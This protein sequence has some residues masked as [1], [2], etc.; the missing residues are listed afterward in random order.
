MITVKNLSFSYNSEPVLNDLNFEAREGE[1]TFILGPNG[2]GK[3][4]LLKCIAGILKPRGAILVENQ[5]LNDISKRELAKKLAY[6]PQRGDTGFL[7]VFDVI[8]LGRKPYMGFGPTNRDYRIV[9]DVMSLL[10]L[11]KLAFR[12]LN[13][14]SG[15]ELQ[16][17]MIARALAQRPRILL[18]DE[19]TNNLDVKNQIEIMRLIR[20]IAKESNISVI[21]TMHD[22][23]LASLYADRIL[24][25]KNGKIFASGGIE[26]L[27]KENIKAVYGVDVEV[28]RMNGKAVILPGD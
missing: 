23:N 9:K 22:L 14:L 2:S 11:E 17:V 25:I 13:E 28:V 18:L 4:T 26:V 6:V 21:S 8:L 27:N 19:P 16:K 20:K 3:T 1:V 24:M 15:G 12:R 10:S 7:T 5:S